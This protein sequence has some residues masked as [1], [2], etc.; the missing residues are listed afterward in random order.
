MPGVTQKD[1]TVNRFMLKPS[2]IVYT[3]HNTRP[4]DFTNLLHPPPA[5]G[6]VTLDIQNTSPL[7]SLAAELHIVCILAF[8]QGTSMNRVC[9]LSCSSHATA[10]L[11]ILTRRRRMA[12]Q[13]VT[14]SGLTCYLK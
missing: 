14:A 1:K 10:R 11:E 4:R 12:V 9:E 2:A 6:P 5:K 8:P 7:S 3:V 13:T